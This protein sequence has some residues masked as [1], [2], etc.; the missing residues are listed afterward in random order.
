MSDTSPAT[1]APQPGA[2]TSALDRSA[3]SIEEARDALSAVSAN[4]D[5]ATGD[6]RS[7]GVTSEDPAQAARSADEIT[8]GADGRADAD[9]A[10]EH[11]DEEAPNTA[12]ADPSAP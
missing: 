11:P 5:V 2:D 6:E 10:D 4:D 3:A 7:A 12:K 8:T 1:D 9:R